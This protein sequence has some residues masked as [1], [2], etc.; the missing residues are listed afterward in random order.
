MVVLFKSYTQIPLLLSQTLGIFIIEHFVRLHNGPAVLP[1]LPSCSRRGFFPRRDC[2]MA[3]CLAE[4]HG[5]IHVCGGFNGREAIWKFV[6]ESVCTWY[7]YSNFWMVGMLNRG[8]SLN[9]FG[10]KFSCLF[11]S[12]HVNMSEDF[13][14]I[15]IHW[16][17]FEMT[18]I[19]RRFARCFRHVQCVRLCKSIYI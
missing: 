11:L 19:Y 2:R 10:F 18:N 5:V 16:P 15:D 3:A 14:Y 13:G 1:V 6:Q 7:T 4:L 8:G 9:R 17:R 12:F